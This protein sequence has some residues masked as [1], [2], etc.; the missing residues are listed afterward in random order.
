[1]SS[2][3]SIETVAELELSRD[4]DSVTSLANL[5]T[6]N[7]LITLAG[8]NSSQAAQDAGKNEH[9]RAFE[10]KYPV[11]AKGNKKAQPGTVS[12]ISK[13]TLL[14]PS[15][16]AQ[17]E[18]YQRITRLSPVHHREAGHK[19]IGAVAT[20]LGSPNEV[21]IFN[22]TTTAPSAFD[23]IQRI[24]L[25]K[26]AEAADVD[27]HELEAEPGK[28]TVAYCT[29]LE[30][31]ITRFKYDFAKKKVVGTLAKPTVVSTIR[32]QVE[33]KKLRAL[34]FLT[35]TLL[36]LLVN[37]PNRGGVELQLL[38]GLDTDGVASIT[39]LRKSLP[40]HVKQAIG[41]D[42]T[43]LDTESGSKEQQAVIAVAGQD[44]SITVLTLDLPG[45]RGGF[46]TVTTLKDVHPVQ[47]TKVLLSPFFSPYPKD[48]KKQ[49]PKPGKHFLKLA[50]ISM[51]N[52]VVV[53]SLPLKTVSDKPRSRHVVV[54]NA[55]ILSTLD[56]NPTLVVVAVTLLT[57]L[58]FFQNLVSDPSILPDSLQPYLARL[59]GQA[60][61][62]ADTVG[63]AVK[64]PAP[65]K[66]PRILDLLHLHRHD[67]REQ[68]KAIVLRPS[69]LESGVTADVHKDSAEAVKEDAQAKSWDELSTHEQAR[70]KE[71]LIKAGHWAKGEG[72]TVLKSVLFSEY[73]GVVGRM[74]AEALAG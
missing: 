25:E 68:K 43:L 38:E 62:L 51:G 34:R 59:T 44:I 53:E 10:I 70:W 42:V 45:L 7:G 20:G 27:I 52:T 32:P 35:P 19:K 4:E 58:L 14:K 23:I 74:A 9:F 55:G 1:M 21:V 17:K 37:L 5:A 31:Y 71:R 46:R 47:M 40:S 50:S 60:P 61:N 39:V 26:G 12:A 66:Q 11:N 2:R 67:L 15:S 29:D 18:S 16:A 48:E 33:K 30:V 6:P 64:Q 56:K 28:F 3:Q 69:E 54:S 22:A 8:V 24:E 72:E 41:M 63:G 13:T 65:P 36:L 57:L 73:A 49:A